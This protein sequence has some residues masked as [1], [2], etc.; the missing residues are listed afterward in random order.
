[1]VEQLFQC[2]TFVQNQLPTGNSCHFFLEKNPFFAS[3]WIL[4]DRRLVAG[5]PQWKV[6]EPVTGFNIQL[7]VSCPTTP[8]CPTTPILT[9]HWVNIEKKIKKIAAKE[10]YKTLPEAQR[11]QDIE[12]KT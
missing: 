5:V 6:Q 2:G 4:D 7:C 11:T 12:S 9:W 3:I 8:N 1:M 10:K